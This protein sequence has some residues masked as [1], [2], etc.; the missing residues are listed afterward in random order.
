M[1]IS[2]YNMQ[3]VENN[4]KGLK[5]AGVKFKVVKQLSE[6]DMI[7]QVVKDGI[8]KLVFIH[9]GKVVAGINA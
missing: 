6:V 2:R 7:W 1:R 4:F 3:V 9:N 5:D 8:K